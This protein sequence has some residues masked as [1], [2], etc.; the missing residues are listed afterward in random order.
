MTK[1]NFLFTFAQ[2]VS[3]NDTLPLKVYTFWIDLF[4]LN[5]F[6]EYFYIF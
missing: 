6:D 2:S 3:V 4:L 1:L 5:D